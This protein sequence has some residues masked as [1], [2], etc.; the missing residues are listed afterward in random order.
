MRLTSFEAIVNALAMAQ[1]RYLV[2]G[3]LAVNAHGYLRFTKDI[4]LVIELHHDNLSRALDALATLGYRPA[5][6]VAVTDFL[7]DATRRRWAEEKGMQ[8]FQLWSDQHPETSIDI[9]VTT[10]F[11]FDEEYGR[12]LV[13]ELSP[14]LP[15]RF[16]SMATLIRMKEQAGRQQDLVD[17]ENLRLRMR[18]GD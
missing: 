11:D 1:A 12:A 6:P 14:G 15:V 3:G 2:A 16:V 5:I 18:D 9:F 10:P 4:D 13:R 17:I 8:V 7:D